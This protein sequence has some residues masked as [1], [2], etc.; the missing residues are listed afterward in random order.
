MTGETFLE[1]DP[2]N[3]ISWNLHTIPGR[4]IV[5]IANIMALTVYL[6]LFYLLGPIIVPIFL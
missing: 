6:T 4:I 5:I 3:I 2:Q 1:P